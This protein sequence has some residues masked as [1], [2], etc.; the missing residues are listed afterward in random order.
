MP[1]GVH[2][3][4]MSPPG[5]RQQL[6]AEVEANPV[7]AQAQGTLD[8]ADIAHRDGRENPTST[9]DVTYR[10]THHMD[11]NDPTLP[12][13]LPPNLRKPRFRRSE[14]PDYLKLVHGIQVSAATLAKY[15]C[16]GGGPGFQKVGRVPLYPRR[17][18]RPP[19]ASHR[20]GA[21]TSQPGMDP[22]VFSFLVTTGDGDG[23]QTRL[24]ANTLPDLIWSLAD[25]PEYRK[26]FGLAARHPSIRVRYGV[27]RFAN[28]SPDTVALL[29]VDPCTGVRRQL[30]SSKAFA[31]YDDTD[32]VMRLADSDPVVAE[33]LPSTCSLLGNAMP[34]WSRTRWRCI[35]AFG[36]HWR[37][38]GSYPDAHCCGSIRIMCCT[39]CSRTVL[40]LGYPLCGRRAVPLSDG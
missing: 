8:H 13:G 7:I 2:C 30:V 1:N 37:G 17:P 40:S 10:R 5:L 3:F 34:V 15:A 4:Y 11:E 20:P 28:L 19:T 39:N 6:L 35:P 26:V 24:P 38:L 23:L 14:A 25:Q 36:W 33:E 27:S 31:H 22:P 18:N 9:T 29:A 16:L 32:A 12:D 21:A